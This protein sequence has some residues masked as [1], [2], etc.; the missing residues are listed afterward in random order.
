MTKVG[1]ILFL[2]IWSAKP[3][4][5]ETNKVKCSLVTLKH[6]RLRF[7]K[8]IGMENRSEVGWREGLTTEELLK[9]ILGEGRVLYSDFGGVCMTAFVKTHRTV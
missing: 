7:S 4:I 9:E 2:A 8:T 3:E 6:R 1:L 5:N